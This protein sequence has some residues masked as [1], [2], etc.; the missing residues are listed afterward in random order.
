MQVVCLNADQRSRWDEFLKGQ[1]F[2]ALLQSWAWGEFKEALGWTA[3]RVAVL[4]RGEIAAG[5]QM[6]VKPLPPGL[7]IAYVP[8]GPAGAWLGGEAADL[9][10]AE[11]KRI[12]RRNRAVFL[13]IEPGI[14]DGAEVQDVLR[15]Q[16][17][18][19][20]RINNQPK[21]TI[22]LDLKQSQDELLTQMRKRTRQYIRHAD[23]EGL[24]VRFGTAEDFPL[25]LQ[26]MNLTGKRARFAV[27]NQKYYQSE[28]EILSGGRQGALLLAYHQDQPVAA[29][30]LYRFGAHAADFHAGS[31]LVPG[32]H[33]NHLLVWES[34][35][36]AQSKG[37]L[38]YDLWGI[39][40]EIADGGEEE[41]PTGRRNDGLWGVYQFK[42]GFS[43]NIVKYVGAYDHIF[44]PSLYSLLFNNRVLY[45]RWW[46]RVSAV[47]DR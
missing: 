15:R 8:R 21:A 13:K 22:L 39:P 9:L 42:R 2:F 17:F 27:R 11:L 10:F 41:S 46:E 25:Y 7:S 29:R 23:K 5:A 26:M 36:W 14:A 6:L 32:L 37:C 34:I 12:A 30:M 43:T 1:P 28:W 40:D 44:I 33:P 45:G 31:L 18:C 24:A 47:M 20:S 3:Y 16:Q 4:D 38:T 35:K 19:R